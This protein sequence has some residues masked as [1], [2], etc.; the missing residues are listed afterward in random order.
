MREL[1]RNKHFSVV[2]GGVPADGALYIQDGVRFK[3]SGAPVVAEQ[4]DVKTPAPAK[5]KVVKAAP[6][7]VKADVED[8]V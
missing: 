6:E 3:P 2:S 7:V 5:S 4:V 1:D 8:I